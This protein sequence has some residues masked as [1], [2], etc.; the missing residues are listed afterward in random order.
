MK[1]FLIKVN[2]AYY[3]GE[4][5]DTTPIPRMKEGWYVNRGESNVIFFM[6]ERQ[7]AKICEGL[8]NLNSHWQRIYNS[9]K[10]DGLE[11]KKIEI[12]QIS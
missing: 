6:E 12:E 4:H 1:T 9:M 7:K 5:L 11:I 10:Y 3:A 8:V 2:G